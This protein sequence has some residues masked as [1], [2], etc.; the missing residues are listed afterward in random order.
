V[1]VNHRVAGS[2]PARGANFSFKLLWLLALTPIQSHLPKICHTGIGFSFNSSSIY[3]TNEVVRKV[4]EGKGGS[5]NK[6]FFLRGYRENAS[7]PTLCDSDPYPLREAIDKAKE[8]FGKIAVLNKIILIEQP[9]GHEDPGTIILTKK[10]AMTSDT[11]DRS[12]SK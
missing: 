6:K 9:D 7:Y 8:Y 3:S 11:A 10:M 1:A 12:A 4:A 5:M 2:S